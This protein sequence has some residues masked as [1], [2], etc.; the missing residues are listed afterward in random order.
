MEAI[1]PILAFFAA[2]S[3]L[4]LIVALVA[5][6]A[7]MYAASKG[8]LRLLRT[9]SWAMLIASAPLAL[10][11]GVVAVLVPGQLMALLMAALWGWNTWSAYQGIR[12]R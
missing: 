3:N 5:M 9:A 12:R 7:R 11:Y 6:F 4:F 1:M 2:W 10:V 8:N